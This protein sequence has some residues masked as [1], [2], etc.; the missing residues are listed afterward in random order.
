M[1]SNTSPMPE[2]MAGYWGVPTQVG[3]SNH[4]GLTAQSFGQMTLAPLPIPPPKEPDHHG[5]LRDPAR[6]PIFQKPLLPQESNKQ[7]LTV[8]PFPAPN[9]VSN[10]RTN[11]LLQDWHPVIPALNNNGDGEPAIYFNDRPLLKE[12]VIHQTALDKIGHSINGV[13]VRLPQAIK[14]GVLGDSDYSFGD[15]LMLGKVP[16]YLGGATLAAIFASGRHR[17]SMARQ[18]PAIVM[19]YLAVAG[20]NKLIDLVVKQQTGVDLGLKYRS[21][22]GEIKP[23]FGDPT[24]SRYDLVGEER[25]R[26]MADKLGLPQDMTDMDDEVQG[27][28]AEMLPRVRLAKA[29][30]GNTIAAVAAGYLARTDA[31]IKVFEPIPGMLLRKKPLKRLARGVRDAV[32]VI[33][34]QL[35]GGER[36]ATGRLNGQMTYSSA[37]RGMGLSQKRFTRARGTAMGVLLLGLALTG[38][39]LRNLVKDKRYEVGDWRPSRQVIPNYLSPTL[40]KA[41]QV[42][43]TDQARIQQQQYQDAIVS[44]ADIQAA[45][46]QGG[47]S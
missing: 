46:R 1:L 18:G 35:T 11:P 37:A 26:H 8:R 14:R 10:F 23:V 42:W 16:Y 4:A 21:A 20:T 22:L 13:F 17:L 28:I 27:V 7:R 31:W 41:R 34:Q 30:L 36:V 33:G 25:Y 24:F 6:L 32:A 19:Y 38:R 9:I 43:Q 12:T 40:N 2:S 47:Q 29:F 39:M 45:Y 5:A 44:A 3:G 15:F